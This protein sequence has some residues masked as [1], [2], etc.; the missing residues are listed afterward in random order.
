MGVILKALPVWEGE[1]EGEGCGMR[2]E[3][4]RCT[5][6]NYGAEIA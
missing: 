4:A 5:Y 6:G 1:G 2:E 3:E